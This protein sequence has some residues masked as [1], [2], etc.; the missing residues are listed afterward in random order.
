M[1]TAP[2]S[3]H[4][5]FRAEAEFEHDSPLPLQLSGH[6][7][8]E[9][10]TEDKPVPKRQRTGR[11]PNPR[12]MSMRDADPRMDSSEW[13][14]RSLIDKGEL[15]HLN[16]GKILRVDREDVDTVIDSHRT[17][18]RGRNSIGFCSKPVAK[19]KCGPGLAWA[20]A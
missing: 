3:A 2:G 17:S 10:P 1:S 12:L 7:R 9:G 4:S 19:D 5:T 15:P 14:K 13:V 18:C 20:S 11:P 8:S 16:F 6:S